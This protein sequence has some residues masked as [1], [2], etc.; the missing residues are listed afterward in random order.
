MSIAGSNG[1]GEE[2]PLTGFVDREWPAIMMREG[3]TGLDM[4]P[5]E[6]HA[7]DSP[8][9]DGSIYRSS[10]ATARQIMLPLHLQ[11]IDR[12]TLK[13]LKRKLSRAL[14]PRNGACKLTFTEADSQ[15]RHLWCY[16]VD[17][18]QGAEGVDTAGF[19]WCRYGIQLI[20]HDPWF[21]SPDLTVAEWTFT[22]GS[23]FLKKGATPFLPITINKGVL[24]SEAVPV[25]NPGDVEAW[26]VWE[27]KGPV[28]SLTFTSPTGA[29]FALPGRSDGQPAVAD[30]RTLSVDTRPGK[31]T[32]VDDRGENYWPLLG[33]NP[34]L[35][36]VPAGKSTVSIVL[37]PG[38]GDPRL[39]LTLRPRYE[40]Y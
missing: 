6:L 37:V 16:Y 32:L 35:W 22:K 29:S 14:N 38:A 28:R 40:S 4:P 15:P 31:K 10:R 3:A 33:P 8:N 5:F 2:I 25:I 7:D 23:A 17:G 21:Y 34:S 30:G 11:G 19:K 1:A 20:A 13:E 39:R 26:P 24:S 36:S 12:R 9:L 27:I 18:M